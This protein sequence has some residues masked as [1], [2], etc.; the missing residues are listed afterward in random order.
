MTD[1]LPP[2]PS[3]LPLCPQDVQLMR[4]RSHVLHTLLEGFVLRRG[5]EILRHTLPQKYEHVLFLRPSSVQGV[6]YNYV[7]DQIKNGPNATSAGPLKAFAMCSK[8]GR[9]KKFFFFPVVSLSCVG[10]RSGT[11]LTC[12]TMR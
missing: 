3:P 1:P 2:P 7:I 6:L 8:V 10:L 9:K 11:I 4:H 5:H 12:I